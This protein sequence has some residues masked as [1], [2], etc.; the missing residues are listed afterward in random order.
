MFF[1]YGRSLPSEL[2]LLKYSPPATSKIYSSNNKLIEEYANEHRVVISLNRVPTVVKQAFLI[3]EDKEFYNH[4]GIS[5]QSLLRAIVENTTKKMWDRRPAGGSTITQQ[6]AKNIL[7]GNKKTISRKIREAI[8]AF[9][10]ENSISKD[11]ILEIYLNHIYLGNGAYGIA[12]AYDYYFG[13]NIN[14]ANPEEAAFLAS[15]PSAPSAY[16]NGGKL[17]KNTK[18]LLKRNAILSEMHNFGYI[19]KEEFLRSISKPISLK[20]RKNKILAP[21]F[22]EEIYRIFSEKFSEAEFFNG[23]YNV[24]TT[25]DSNLQKIAQKCLE[26]GLINHEKEYNS[27]NGALDTEDNLKTIEQNIPRTVNRIFPV[28]VQ[29]ISKGKFFGE[30]SVGKKLEIENLLN[31]EINLGDK[32]FCRECENNKYEIYQEPSCSGAIV[33][34]DAKSGD[35]L[36][37]SGGYSFDINHFNCVTQAYRQ[38]GSAIKPFIYASALE[39]GMEEYDEIEDKPVVLKLGNGKFYSPKNHNKKVYGKMSMRDGLIYSR[40]LATINLAQKTGAQNVSKTLQ[41]FRLT[42]KNFNI[43]YV[44]GACEVTL[45]QITSAFSVFLNEGDMVCPRFIKSISCNQKNLANK[46]SFDELTRQKKVENIVCKKTADTIKNMLRDAAKYGT[47][48]SRLSYVFDKYE[49][50]IDVGGKTGSSNDFKDAWFIGYV[51]KGERTLI[52]GIFTGYKLPKTIGK[53]A[54][55]SKIALPIF[56][57][58]LEKFV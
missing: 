17:K 33:V 5:I 34:M 47:A 11:K 8:M 38:P 14:N 12:E 58:F 23:G 10:I 51:T 7:V 2:T 18:I 50:I 52:V 57:N 54:Y 35:I 43:S 31:Y 25:M 48:G 6:V 36:A 26:D 4:S 49:G 20:I 27:W 3:A 16:T 1:Y 53:N 19:T 21:Y 46:N 56:V 37:M 9:R 28:V 45:L 13:K 15:L 30:D 55:G 44:L 24:V 41:K 29:K 32:V 39:Y 22:A 40:N 42:D